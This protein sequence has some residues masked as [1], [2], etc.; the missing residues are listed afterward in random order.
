MANPLPQTPLAGAFTPGTDQRPSNY[1]WIVCALLFFATTINYID[2]QILALIK[3]I[4][5]DQL[6]WT[7]EQFGYTNALF[8]LS[9]AVSLLI[10]G[11]FV[12]KYGT[13][14]GYAVSIAAWSVAAVGHAL[15]ASISGFYFARVMLG[16]GEGGNFPSA[17]KAVALWF[18]KRERATATAIFNSGTNVGAIVAPLA[19]PAIALTLGW[20][21]AFIFAGIAG[22]LW[23][24]L[25]IPFYDVPERIR[26]A[27][28]AELEHIRSDHDDT[29]RDGEKVSWLGLLG[30]RQT[31]AFVV[32][33]ALTDP[34]WWF[35]LTWLPDFFKQTRH[36]DIKQSGYMLAT[37]YG[38][39]TVLSIGGGLV[40][41]ALVKSGWSV[42]RARK[43]GMFFFACCVLPIVFV[44]GVND[45][46][47]V[48]L[49]GLACAAHQAWS[50]NLFTTASDMFPKRAVASVVGLGGMAGSGLG[51]VFPILAGQLL[52]R[53]KAQNNIS[54]GY[55]VLF[56]VC[57]GAYLLA[58][59]L[60]HVLAPK[61]VMT[62]LKEA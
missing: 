53:F 39:A 14:I 57:A 16:L 31:W 22:F 40:V 28:D 12:D 34:V 41:G 46:T 2:R 29:S 21:W 47:A 60:Q 9:Y 33:K 11:W 4:L 38:M 27:N 54:G 19:V 50:A 32:A 25:W 48:V 36:L 10:F 44:K 56:A 6:K 5:D 17:I 30:Y 24:F 49:I 58:F 15:V 8:Q 45:W 20:H 61:F 62:E 26:A 3:P 1:R 59:V 13:K 43:T 55:A 35:F 42:T 52:D 37:I 7:N 51:F 23:L 18:P